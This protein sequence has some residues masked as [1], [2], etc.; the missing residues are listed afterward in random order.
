MNPRFAFFGTPPFAA[1]ILTTLLEQGWQPV[2]VVSERAKPTGRGLIPEVSAV[3]TLAIKENL[4]LATPIHAR[5]IAPLLQAL[6]LDL[7]IVVA[8]GKLIPTTALALPRH[9]FVNVHASL[10]PRWRGASPLQAAILAGDTETG[11]SYMVMEP[12]LDTGPVI[13][14]THLALDGTETTPSLLTKLAASSRDTLVPALER[15]LEGQ[16]PIAQDHEKATYAPKLVKTDGLVDLATEDPVVLDRK[17]RALSPWPGVYTL[18]FGPR[19][20]IKSGYLAGERYVITTVQW[21][22][23][24]PVDGATFARAHPEILT[25]L[26]HQVTLGAN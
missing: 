24:K 4:P 15:Y 1:T 10:L 9:G 23:K 8:Y 25:K 21:E 6:T 20:L 3:A 22:G 17:V 14:Q 16:A 5:E 2:L 26:P 19:L 11:L 18:E 12:S 13:E 7:A